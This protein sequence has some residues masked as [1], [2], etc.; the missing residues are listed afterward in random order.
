MTVYRFRDFELYV[1]TME[2]RRAGEPVAIRPQALRLLHYLIDHRARVV[3]KEE[4]RR[5]LWGD[6]IVS[7]H[8]LNQCV[9]DVRK[10]LGDQHTK[11]IIVTAHGLGLRFR[12][13]ASPVA[14]PKEPTA[15]ERSSSALPFDASP[16]IGFVGREGEF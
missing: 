14:T 12:G 13:D 5:T 15:G 11:S 9:Y 2:L 16:Q 4:I 6:V 3:S 8:T 10:A 7:Q 1:A